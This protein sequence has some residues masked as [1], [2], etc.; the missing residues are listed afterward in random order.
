MLEAVLLVL[1]LVLLAVILTMQFRTGRARH[2]HEIESA[3]TRAIQG[4][5]IL[6]RLGEFEA[7]TQEIARA[8]QALVPR[9]EELQRL[10]ARLA[11]HTHS[12]E[13]SHRSLE[14]LLKVPASRGAFGELALEAILSD[15][16]PPDMFG[17]RKQVPGVGTPDAYIKTDQGLIC[18]DSK[19]PLT[20][21]ENAE[22][23]DDPAQAEAFTK[24]FLKDAKGHLDKVRRDYVRPQAGTTPFAFVFIPSEAVYYFLLKHGFPM[25][26]DF[27]GQGVQVTS[28]LGLGHKLSMI[29]AGIHAKKLSE[30]AEVIH[31]RLLEIADAFNKVDEN[32]RVF[33]TRHLKNLYN[34]AEELDQDYARLR[35]AFERLRR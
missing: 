27:A 8:Q 17:I 22:N 10:I 18:I 3:V 14:Q 1:I 23:T 25:L 16:L 28:P 29:R 26:R 7:R 12:V 33:Y 6:P 13:E 21:F 19:F 9:F 5:A 2:D 20:N 31:D 35:D 11:E 34:K 30:Q 15:Q 24:Q 4:T 32:W